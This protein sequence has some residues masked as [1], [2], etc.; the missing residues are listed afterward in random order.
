MCL[1]LEC[2][3]LVLVSSAAELVL[4]EL[5]CVP[6][7]RQCICKYSTAT[8][9]AAT[10][11]GPCP[12]TC[13]RGHAA[14][15]PSQR[16]QQ[17]RPIRVCKWQRQQHVCQ[18]LAVVV[19]FESDAPVCQTAAD[20][21]THGQ[22]GATGLFPYRCNPAVQPC[23]DAHHIQHLAE[24]DKLLAVLQAGAGGRGAIGTAVGMSSC[25]VG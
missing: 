24:I 10:S 21:Q 7:A 9:A 6:L 19:V 23:D 2:S 18:R 20:D 12:P 1:C 22:H 15:H 8:P 4:V 3:W 16:L 25:L 13:F 14:K 11:L 17:P 5:A